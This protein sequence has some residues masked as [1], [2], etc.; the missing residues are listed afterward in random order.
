MYLGNRLDPLVLAEMERR[1]RTSC[2]A[3]GIPYVDYRPIIEPF[4]RTGM[5][6]WALNCHDRNGHMGV[7]PWT[8]NS[9]G[10]LLLS[11]TATARL[12]S[13][14]CSELRPAK[15]APHDTEIVY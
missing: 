8:Y 2:M 7:I 5:C 14:V 1:I 10:T 13:T 6:G 9:T 3:D 12:L 11:R 4:Y 15:R